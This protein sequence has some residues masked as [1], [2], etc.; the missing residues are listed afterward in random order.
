MP[1]SY[2][3]RQSTRAHGRSRRC[4][5]TLAEALIASII[6]SIS[7]T[8]VAAALMAGAQQTYAAVETTRASQLVLAMIDEVLALPYAD[9]D[10]ASAPGPEAGETTRLAFDNVDDYHGYTEVAGAI[11][12]AVGTAYPAAYDAYERTVQVAT[13]SEQPAGL[14]AVSGVTITVAVTDANGTRTFA[15][16]SRFVADPS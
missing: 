11:V 4:A 1:T 3:M 7:V 13:S 10:G 12:D 14:P 9:P 5:L 2:G 15:G 6:L 16:A 8:A